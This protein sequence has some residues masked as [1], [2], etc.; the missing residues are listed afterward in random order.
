MREWQVELLQRSTGRSLDSWNEQ[1]HKDAP[2]DERG[3]RTW[4]AEHGVTGYCQMLLVHERFGY[5]DFFTKTAD[6]LVEEQYADRPELRPIYDALVAIL[7]QV[8]EATVQ[9]RKTYVSLLT[10]RRT[11]AVVAPTT[12]TRVDLG[13]RWE[14]APDS[15]RLS[16]AGSR[17]GSMVT[18]KVAL[19]GLDDLDDEVIDW[20]RAAY[21]AN[22]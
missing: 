14:D 3:V 9:T 20:L 2:D 7:P 4:L 18:V 11:F 19:R 5:P 1:V 16:P 8:G 12:R 15:P 13:L 10:P 17:L 6:E 21:Q 22:L